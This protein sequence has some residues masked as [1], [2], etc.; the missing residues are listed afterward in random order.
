[1]FFFNFLSQQRLVFCLGLAGSLG[2]ALAQ[3]AVGRHLRHRLARQH[4][5]AHRQLRHPGASP[6]QPPVIFYFVLCFFLVEE[7]RNLVLLQSFQFHLVIMD[8]T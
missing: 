7:L 6:C 4:G 8:Y 1:M 2:A 5:H 3:R